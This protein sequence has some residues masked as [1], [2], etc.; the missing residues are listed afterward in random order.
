MEASRRPDTGCCSPLVSDSQ[1]SCSASSEVTEVD[2]TQPVSNVR[3]LEEILTT[4]TAT[5]RVGAWLMGG[6]AALSLM[7]AA[8]GLYGC[9]TR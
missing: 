5:R 3:T 7:L 2:P 6:F 9:P 4:E 1:P 8:V